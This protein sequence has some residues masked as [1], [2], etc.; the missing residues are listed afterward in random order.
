[1]NARQEYMIE[2]PLISVIIIFLN[3]ERFIEEAIE[4]V[5][6]QTY[7]QWELLLVDDGST[8]ASTRV[9]RYYANKTP[10]KVIYLEHHERQNRGMS[11]SRNVGIKHAKGEYIAFLD[12][13]DVWLPNKLAEQVTILIS[14]PK[15][16]MVYG[17]TLYWWSWTGKPED[18]I[19]DYVQPH[20]IESD[21]LYSP[22]NLLSLFLRGKAAVPCT[23][24]ILVRRDVFQRTGGFEESFHDMY[25]DQAFYAKVCLS[26]FI[27][28]SNKC[29]EKYRQHPDAMSTVSSKKGQ[30]Y[31]ARR[32]FLNWLAEHLSEKMITNA[33]IW[34]AIKREEWLY[35][36]PLWFDH[37]PKRT[38]YL[39]RW[40]KKWFLRFEEKFLPTSICSK[41][42]SQKQ[43]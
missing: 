38:Q 12:A 39:L 4:S 27:F 29:L 30:D 9:A 15:T 10:G 36:Y 24:S 37:F 13:D 16:G 1:M 41:I 22:P 35:S 11:A 34:Q 6:A 5:F 8:D 2:N 28:L 23:C 32:F 31:S 40:T 3:A 26:E 25:E 19:R 21:I 20:T 18:R 33:E 14:Q 43:A 42:W 17:Q 7:E